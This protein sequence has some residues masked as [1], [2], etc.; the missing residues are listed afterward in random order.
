MRPP[1]GQIAAPD[2]P[3]R[4][5]WIN[6]ASLRMDEQRGRPVLIEFFDVCRVSSLRTLPYIRAWHDR[7]PGLRVISVHAPGYPPSHDEAVVRDG[8]KRLEISHAVALDQRFELW[9]LYDNEGWPARYLFDQE[10]RLFEIHYGEGA[11]GDTERA[12]QEL[13]DAPGELVA[14]VRPEDDPEALLVVPTAEQPG[15]YCG[16]YEAGEVWAVLEGSGTICVDREPRDVDHS[17]AHRLIAHGVHTEAA[18]ALVPGD[19][20]ICHA[21]C[22][23]PGLAP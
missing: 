10:L 22:F 14:P 6:V 21:T 12:I 13:L 20:V 23:T 8:V 17:G 15:A 4:T 1:A 7:Y 18:L 9:Q 2:F 5:G 19:G 16:P 11:Y 3:E